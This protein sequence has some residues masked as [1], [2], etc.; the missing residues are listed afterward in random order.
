MGDVCESGLGLPRSHLCLLTQTSKA[1]GGSVAK[2]KKLHR[3]AYLP[4]MR[5][6]VYLGMHAGVR[7]LLLAQRD[8]AMHSA[9]VQYT[10]WCL[11][12]VSKL[13]IYTTLA[14]TK[15]RECSLVFRP[16][17]ACYSTTLGKIRAVFRAYPSCSTG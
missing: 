5:L 12:Q 6:A 1:L 15:Q 16:S 3:L 4:L 9:T 17:P 7:G 10:D 14:N 2:S 13:K 8:R 11:S